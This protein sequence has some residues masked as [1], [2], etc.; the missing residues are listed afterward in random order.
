MRNE[1]GHDQNPRSSFMV[2]ITWLHEIFCHKG[3]ADIREWF[4]LIFLTCQPNHS[5]K[6][7]NMCFGVKLSASKSAVSGVCHFHCH[8]ALRVGQSKGLGWIALVGR[9]GELPIVVHHLWWHPRD[10]C[11]ISIESCIWTLGFCVHCHSFTASHC[12]VDMRSMTNFHK[13]EV[14]RHQMTCSHLH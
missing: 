11:A 2:N 9:E 5:K 8:P 3:N 14:E 12:E 4:L 10:A 1:D 7:Q 13:S 6:A